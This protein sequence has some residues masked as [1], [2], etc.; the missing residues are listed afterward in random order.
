MIKTDETLTIGRSGCGK[1]FLVLSLLK[2]KT[3]DD[4]YIICKT[5]NQF[6][7]KYYNQSSEISFLED[8]REKTFVF[9]DLLGSKEVK[10]I[11]AFFYSWSLPKS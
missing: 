1:I 3:P 11:Q 4:V 7:S 5:D 9:D 2:D 10:D 6:S 8:Y